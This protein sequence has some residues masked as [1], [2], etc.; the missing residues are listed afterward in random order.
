VLPAEIADQI[1]AG[2]VVERPASVVKEL[3]ENALDAGARCVAVDLE[4]AGTAL[5]A[6]IDD[7]EGMN[8]DDAVIAFARHAT[9]KLQSVDDLG[10]IATLGFRG[11]ALASIAARVAHD[12]DDAARRRSRRHAGGDGARAHKSRRARSGAPVGTRVEVA[13][14]FGNVPARR[15]FSEGA[16]HR[17]RARQR[18]GDA[19]PR[20]AWPQV[21]FTLRH[22]GRVLVELAAVA[23]DAER[24]IR[25]SAANAPPRCCRSR[26]APAAR[27]RTGGS[28]IRI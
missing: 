28:A 24:I 8:A 6:V 17:G 18:A 15:K 7:G 9:S 19:Q 2:E 20:S 25:S 16:G 3:V 23:D 10:A 5:I 14:L 13:E 21:G 4:Q 26:T 1:A 27:W 22:G 11:E 12:A